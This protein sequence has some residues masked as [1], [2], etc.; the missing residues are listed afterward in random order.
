RIQAI[1]LY[2]SLSPKDKI[3]FR[4]SPYFCKSYKFLKDVF[5]M[6]PAISIAINIAFKEGRGD[7]AY[8]ESIR[9]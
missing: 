9:I 3:L 5:Y 2:P 6:F 4:E 1:E 8:F 7:R